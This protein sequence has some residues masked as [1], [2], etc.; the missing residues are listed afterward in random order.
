MTMKYTSY[1]QIREATGEE[2]CAIN[3]DDYTDEELWQ[4]QKWMFQAK[5]E[6]IPVEELIG[7]SESAAE[8]LGLCNENIL[9]KVINESPDEFTINGKKILGIEII[10]Y[11]EFS[12]VKEYGKNNYYRIMH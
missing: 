10:T 6:F 5:Q 11:P 4:V 9:N 2:L 7:M 8:K 12:I 1:K 3:P